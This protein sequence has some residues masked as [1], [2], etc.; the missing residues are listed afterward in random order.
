MVIDR[1]GFIIRA[2]N[3]I[4]TPDSWVHVAM[5]WGGS[6]GFSS[7]KLYI[8]GREVSY[9]EETDGTLGGSDSGGRL[10]IGDDASKSKPLKGALDDLIIWKRELSQSE[11]EQ[12]YRRAGDDIKFQIRSCYESDCGDKGYAG[13]GQ[14]P[15]KWFSQSEMSGS[16]ELPYFTLSGEQGRYF[17]YKAV[18]STP[19]GVTAPSFTNVI[20][21]GSN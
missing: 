11:I 5:T 4:V 10:R 9:S 6:A 14:N 16:N 21:D 17:Q 18:L 7:I 15:S 8:N 12:I 2:S 3:A 13:V 1:G 19:S 20:I